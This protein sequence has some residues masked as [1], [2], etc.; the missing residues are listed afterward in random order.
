MGFSSNRSLTL[1]ITYIIT[2]AE[3]GSFN[4]EANVRFECNRLRLEFPELQ[5]YKTQIKILF[6]HII[7]ACTQRQLF[8]TLL[9]YN[10]GIV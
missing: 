4:K 5:N 1:Q 3:L 6:L 7:Y 8:Y 9:L 10:V 2:G